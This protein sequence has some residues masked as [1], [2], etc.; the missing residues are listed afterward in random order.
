M[1]DN[2]TRCHDSLP[3]RITVVIVVWILTRAS[4]IVSL[5]AAFGCGL[6]V[7]RMMSAYLPGC[8]T[9]SFP[10][11][12][13]QFL[14]VGKSEQLICF[15][16]HDGS[17]VFSCCWVRV[18]ERIL[19]FLNFYVHDPNAYGIAAAGVSDLHQVVDHLQG[20]GAFPPL[21]PTF[22]QPLFQHTKDC[23]E[24]FAAVVGGSSEF[25]QLRA[26]RSPCLRGC[27]FTYFGLNRMCTTDFRF[28]CSRSLR[29]LGCSAVNHASTCTCALRESLRRR[30]TVLDLR[31]G[32]R[33][34]RARASSTPFVRSS[35][36]CS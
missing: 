6:H 35:R 13:K 34:W 17:D 26:C 36:I 21:A 32:P 8:A 30:P 25:T 15:A 19:D 9:G 3:S 12:C 29:S 20:L 18:T 5:A 16:S 24:A 1:H 14:V 23:F 31:F 10:L 11:F 2:V 33:V 28:E 7:S 4:F 22:V 27:S